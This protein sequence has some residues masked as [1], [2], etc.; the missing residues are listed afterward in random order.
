MTTYTYERMMEAIENTELTDVRDTYYKKEAILID[1]VGNAI[2]NKEVNCRPYG[3]GK[4]INYKGSLLTNTI[5]DI[6]FADGLTKKYSMAHVLKSKSFT[7]I[8]DCEMLFNVWVIVSSIHEALTSKLNELEQEARRLE[9]EAAK[10]AEEERKAEERY[11]KMKAK[12]IS[13]FEALTKSV[14]SKSLSNEFYYALGWLAKNAGTIS[15]AMPDYLLS[16]FEKHFGTEAN[17]KV[18]DSRKRTSGGYPMQWALSMKIS[19]PNRLE[20][21]IPGYF[22]KYLSSSK[23]AITNTSFIWDLVDNYGFSFG[24]KQDI[25]KIKSYVPTEYLSSFLG[26]LIN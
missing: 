25:E 20:N 6:E 16:Y 18:V 26:G 13:D 2:I 15:A 1:L 3:I 5:V 19:L 23:N 14:N 21:Y 24:R 17:P 10:K 22:N 11:Q 7:N 12:S 4:I 9:A 8:M